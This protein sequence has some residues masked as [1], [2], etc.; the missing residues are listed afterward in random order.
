[1]WYSVLPW[2]KAAKAATVQLSVPVLAALG[3]I[4]VLGESMTLR[5][6]VASVA[7]LGGIGLV[8][9]ERHPSHGAQQ[10][11]GADAATRRG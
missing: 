1:M 10:G 8:I 6:A 3:G 7:V 2:L 5:L 11:A 4:L 9:L